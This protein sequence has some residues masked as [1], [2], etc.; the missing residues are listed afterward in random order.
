MSA[1]R[2]W[3]GLGLMA[4]IAAGIAWRTVSSA[5]LV[6]PAAEAAAM[7]LQHK[8][9]LAAEAKERALLQDYVVRAAALEAVAR[10]EIPP[11]PFRPR[12]TPAP[13]KKNDQEP[14]KVEPPV[15]VLTAVD[16]ARPEVVLKIGGQASGLLSRGDTWN[17]WTVLSISPTSVEVEGFG[18]KH[19]LPV[20]SR[21]K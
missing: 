15:V 1:S 5:G 4:A 18:E 8:T 3:A 16:S 10:E 19:R 14:L 17:G 21:A 7:S 2:P 20:P 6:L 13:A 12:W 9:F 11:D